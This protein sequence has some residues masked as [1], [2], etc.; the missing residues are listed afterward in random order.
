M[1]KLSPEYLGLNFTL[2]SG[3]G[4]HEWAFQNPWGTAG[5]CIEGQPKCLTHGFL[6]NVEISTFSVLAQ[7][8]SHISLSE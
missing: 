7:W 5:S 2:V 3:R 1:E 4:E 6:V 8:V